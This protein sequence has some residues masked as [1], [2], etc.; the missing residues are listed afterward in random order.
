MNVMN[1]NFIKISVISYVLQNLNRVF[2]VARIMYL[3]NND[4]KNSE[5]IFFKIT[6]ILS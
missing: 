6:I 5:I 4:F 2:I 3:F 1:V